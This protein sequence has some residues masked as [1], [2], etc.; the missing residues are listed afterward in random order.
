M[1]VARHAITFWATQCCWPS[2]RLR[3][4]SFADGEGHQKRPDFIVHLPEDKHLI[5]DAKVS[6]KAYAAYH[7]SESDAE[8]SD[9]LVN[10]PSAQLKAG[11][12][13]TIREKAKK[14]LRIQS[15]MEIAGQVGLPE[16]VDVDDKKMAGVLKSLADREEILPDIN[17]NLVVELYS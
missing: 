11:D 15:A 2:W 16:W 17:E 5:I 4:N 14:Q 6:L 7:S 12:A 10:I 13:I 1:D 8:R 9:A 3:Q